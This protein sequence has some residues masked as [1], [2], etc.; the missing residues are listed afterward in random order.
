MVLVAVIC[1]YCELRF[2]QKRSLVGVY[3]LDVMQFPVL[4]T[5]Y[6][7]LLKCVTDMV[8]V[9][10]VSLYSVL[11]FGLKRYLVAFYFRDV[12]QFPVL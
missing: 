1:S 3:F 2:V 7:T 6:F 12:M 9:A 5:E 8:L 10:D 4:Y 11:R